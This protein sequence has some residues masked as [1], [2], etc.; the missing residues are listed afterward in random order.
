MSVES[1]D[2]TRDAIHVSEAA[3]IH[4]KKQLE[5]HG[6]R[7]VRISVKESGCT[8][9]MYVMDEVEHSETG[10][11]VMNLDNGLEVYIDPASLPVLQ[12][13]EIAYEKEGINRTIKFHNPNVTAACGCGE[14]FTVN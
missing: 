1:F 4:L 13:T 11:L 5:K 2:V 8:G 6:G 10:D 14:S 12:G 3:A 9:Y 7:G